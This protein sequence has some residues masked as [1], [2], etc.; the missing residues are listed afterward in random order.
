MV[1]WRFVQITACM[2]PPA[3][4]VLTLTIIHGRAITAPAESCENWIGRTISEDSYF[5]IETVLDH[6]DGIP[7][8]DE[9]ETTAD[10]KRRF[11]EKLSK[12]TSPFVI[13]RDEPLEKRYRKWNYRYNADEGVLTINVGILPGYLRGDTGYTDALMKQTSR[14]LE[15]DIIEVS[16][17]ILRQKNK[18]SLY[19]TSDMY[20]YPTIREQYGV[21]DIIEKL[22]IEARKAKSIKEGSQTALVVEMAYPYVSKEE[23]YIA[24]TVDSPKKRHI[25]DE[26][27]WVDIQ[28]ALIIDENDTISRAYTPKE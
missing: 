21:T 6:F 23:Y 18:S 20:F 25:T 2:T 10:H 12:M 24:P 22:R 9:F 27:I 14:S 28:C 4:I 11:S 8:K 16:N 7:P 3:I 26:I 19:L 17:S 13:K 1:H 15:E 5:G